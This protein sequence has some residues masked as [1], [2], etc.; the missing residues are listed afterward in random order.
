MIREILKLLTSLFMTMTSKDTIFI[1][2]VN[3]F[4]RNPSQF[5]QKYNLDTT[6]FPI[7][8]TFLIYNEDLKNASQFQAQTLSL[9]ECEISHDTC[10]AFC[11]EFGNDC[12]FSNRMSYFTTLPNPSEILIQGPKKPLSFIKQF[13][14][15]QPHCEIIADPN[16]KYIGCSFQHINRNIFVCDFAQ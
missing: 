13:L 12:S 5:L 11:H 10:N 6:C 2:Y 4:R 8:H 7:H 15:S 9:Q 1:G 3:E 14:L 16:N